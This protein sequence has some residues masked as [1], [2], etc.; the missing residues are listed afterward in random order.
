MFRSVFHLFQ[1]ISSSKRQ[2]GNWKAPADAPNRALQNE[3]CHVSEEASDCDRN[4]SKCGFRFRHEIYSS[5]GA[6]V[7]RNEVMRSTTDVAVWLVYFACLGL[8]VLGVSP[9]LD[10]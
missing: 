3:M 7:T 6:H 9:Q 10:V 4:R 5:R 2:A 1:Y 8:S